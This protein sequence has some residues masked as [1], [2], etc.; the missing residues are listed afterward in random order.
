MAKRLERVAVGG[1]GTI[2]RS[3]AAAG[4]G[5]TAGGGGGCLVPPS[6]VYGWL[7]LMLLLSGM[8]L[9]RRRSSRKMRG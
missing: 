6:G 1:F 9:A 4:G 3:P 8:A 7:P 5:A 2:L